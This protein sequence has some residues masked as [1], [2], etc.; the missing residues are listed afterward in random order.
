[1]LKLACEA[2]GLEEVAEDLTKLL[3]S[4]ALAHSRL[5]GMTT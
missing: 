3:W 1:V 5:T 2:T 4:V